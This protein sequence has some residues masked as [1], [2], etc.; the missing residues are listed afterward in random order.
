MSTKMDSGQELPQANQM[1]QPPPVAKI[2]RIA[3]VGFI[4][5]FLIPIIGLI[6]S[7]IGLVKAKDYGGDGRGIAIAGISLSSFLMLASIVVI[8]VY[9]I[10]GKDA[11][12][13]ISL[14]IAGIMLIVGIGI[15]VVAFKLSQQKKKIK[16]S[17]NNFTQP[18]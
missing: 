8:M 2:N 17:D 6:V 10:A 11:L 1:Q 15:M 3:L 7:I 12:V 5:A 16:S 9:S 18:T 4:L 14:T 13:F